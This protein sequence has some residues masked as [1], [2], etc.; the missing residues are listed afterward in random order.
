MRLRLPALV[1][2]LL[3]GALA[4]PDAVE[5]DDDED[6]SDPPPPAGGHWPSLREAQAVC[7]LVCV[8]AYP[9]CD[10]LGCA[11]SRATAVQEACQYTCC[12]DTSHTFCWNC[13][14]MGPGEKPPAPPASCKPS[15]TSRKVSQE[16]NAAAK[17]TDTPPPDNSEPAPGDPIET[18]E[19]AAA[20]YSHE[21]PPLVDPK[22]SVR[23]APTVHPKQLSPLATP[24]TVAASH[25]DAAASAAHPPASP[26]RSPPEDA[27]TPGRA[28]FSNAPLTNNDG[29]SSAATAHNQGGASAATTHNQGGPTPITRSGEDIASTPDANGS[30]SNHHNLPS[31]SSE[32]SLQ[33]MPSSDLLDTVRVI[34]A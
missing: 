29:D 4:E 12:G 6:G 7:E 18:M 20:L 16:N 23:G 25:P 24:P 34:N 9:R 21:P 33:G 28:D 32:T 14:E 1:V 19:K 31:T 2:V 5:T 26:V 17:L 13:L 27:T 8:R 30:P 3:C 11:P 22:T 15:P 10:T